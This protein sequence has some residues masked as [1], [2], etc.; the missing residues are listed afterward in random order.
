[1]E[2]PVDAFQ[3]NNRGSNEAFLSRK[4]SLNAKETLNRAAV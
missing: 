1:V 3:A 2:K 4:K